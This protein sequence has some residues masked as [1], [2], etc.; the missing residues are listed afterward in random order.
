MLCPSMRSI[1]C[2][3]C[4]IDKVDIVNYLLPAT[5]LL[6]IN[7]NYCKPLVT[8]SSTEWHGMMSGADAFAID[9]AVVT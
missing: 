9:K 1:L 7:N 8:R 5:S 2:S 6:V 4:K 3:S